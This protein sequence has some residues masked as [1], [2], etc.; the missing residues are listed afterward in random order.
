M[1]ILFGFITLYIVPIINWF[2]LCAS[3]RAEQQA[4]GLTPTFS[5]GIATLLCFVAGTNLCYLQA[6]QNLV[7]NAVQA[8]QGVPA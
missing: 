4:A 3:I 5:T 2:K 8:R 7:V 6:Q 1:W